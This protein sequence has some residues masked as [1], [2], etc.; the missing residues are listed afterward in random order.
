VD[1]YRPFQKK[2]TELKRLEDYDAYHSWS[3]GQLLEEIKLRRLGHEHEDHLYLVD[4]LMIN[5]HKFFEMRHEFRQLHTTKE[6][7]EEAKLQHVFIDESKRWEPHALMI[8]IADQLARNAVSM[9]NDLLR[10]EQV[11]REVALKQRASPPEARPSTLYG[12]PKALHKDVKVKDH[13]Q[14]QK[15]HWADT[16]ETS[17]EEV[18]E[19]KT[20]KSLVHAKLPAIDAKKTSRIFIKKKR[21]VLKAEIASEIQ[22]PQVVSSKGGDSG[23]S[24]GRQ[25]S[26]TSPSVSASPS[27]G[28]GSIKNVPNIRPSEP[29]AR[30]N[31]SHGTAAVPADQA[32]KDRPMSKKRARPLEVEKETKAE[33]PKRIKTQLTPEDQP[34]IALAKPD[35]L[36]PIASIIFHGDG[37]MDIE[38]DTPESKSQPSTRYAKDLY[39]KGEGKPMKM[40]VSKQNTITEDITAPA[41]KR[42]SRDDED[43][44]IPSKKAKSS[45]ATTSRPQKKPLKGIPADERVPGMMYVQLPD[46]SYELK[47]R[48]KVAARVS[49]TGKRFIL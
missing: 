37:E 35:R 34:R 32:P 28:A 15:D 14:H 27:S 10:A 44:Q 30:R 24:T 38:F 21:T 4:I 42:K 41:R 49:D 3:N 17:P 23:Y 5:D 20:S 18:M 8:H 40:D 39:T 2:S 16:N 46:G 1:T 12:V 22:K 47:K 11:A 13:A 6:L 29:T 25:K 36:K 45:T 48:K 19:A 33:P 31:K 43:D 7:L 26:S 9:H